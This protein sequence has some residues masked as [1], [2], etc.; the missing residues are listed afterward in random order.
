[1]SL[2]VAYVSILYKRLYKQNSQNTCTNN[3]MSIL[4]KQ[5]ATSMGLVLSD[6]A[7]N[8]IKLKGF[9]TESH[10]RT[11]KLLYELFIY[12]ENLLVSS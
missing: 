3:F 1:M 6:L 9:L 5:K 12:Y 10:K 7:I 2:S 4:Y 8:M 11:C